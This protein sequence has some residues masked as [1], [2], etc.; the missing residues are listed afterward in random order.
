MQDLE[1]ASAGKNRFDDL[2]RLW[3]VAPVH[4]ERTRDVVRGLREGL[5]L[6]GMRALEV[7]A[8]TGLLSFALSGDLGRILATDPSS[9]MVDVLEE[10]IRESGVSN[11]RALRADDSLAGV[12]GPFDLVVSQM[13]LHHVP[14]VDAFLAR[15][16][17][18]LRAG[19]WIAI[20]D[21]DPE[22]GSFHGPEVR[23]V[24]LGFD[25]ADLGRRL[26]AAGFG[27]VRVSTVH[28]MLRTV[29]GKARSYPIFLCLAQVSGA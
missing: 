21:L 2:A 28:T 9:G 11:V 25:R 8:G 1:T 27:G 24:H 29:D 26:T 19:G 14:D 5:D 4:L 15:A 13:A 16:R 17:T 12:E 10:K 23:D 22:D 3:D 20:A 6:V 7:G 18:L